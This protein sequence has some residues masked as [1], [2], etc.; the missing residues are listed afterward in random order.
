MR[1]LYRLAR[2]LLFQLPPE[3]AHRLALL[4]LKSGLHP[5]FRAAEDLHLGVQLWGL[6]FPNPLG[7]AAG[8]DK[9]AE[10]PEALARLGFGFVEVGSLTPLPQIGNP[11]PR[12]FRLTEDEALINR[13]GFN[14]CG[15]VSALRRLESR[16]ASP[17]II[18]VN[19]GA[20][21]DSGDPL[22]DYVKGVVAFSGVASY[23]TINISSPNTPGLRDLQSAG[24][25]HR[26]LARLDEARRR[27]ARPRPLLLKIA[28]D[29]N[30]SEL[31][32]IAE[33]ALANRVDGLILGNTT[34][35][36]PPLKSPHASEPGG[37][38]GVPL[39]ELSTRMLAQ[40]YRLTLGRMPLVGVGGVSSAE[41]AWQKLRAGASLVQLYS[42]LV[43]EGPSIVREINKGLAE[44]L[45]ASGK[46]SIAEITGSGVSDWL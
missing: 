44:R 23:I 2:P 9:N 6:N 19:L 11:P 34:V 16:A 13:L 22:A 17:A 21:R 26:L 7:L 31:A 12:L 38:S 43:Y 27:L 40:L 32:F 45:R 46:R 5:A 39:F 33:T 10:A 14:N 20:N 4:I 35:S 3:T 24:E 30:E 37:L 15:F 18:G 29:L 1:Y 36:R 28:P 41:A 25:L 42:A 8:F